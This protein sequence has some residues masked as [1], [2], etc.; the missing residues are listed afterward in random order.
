MTA[1]HRVDLSLVPLWEIAEELVHQARVVQSLELRQ[2]SELDRDARAAF[3]DVS[4]AVDD[5]MD[6]FDTA[7]EAAIEMVAVGEPVLPVLHDLASESW[8]RSL[9][10]RIGDLSAAA[11]RATAHYLDDPTRFFAAD[12]T[13]VDALVRAN[14]TYASQPDTAAAWRRT[15]TLRALPGS[16]RPDAPGPGGARPA[17]AENHDA[18]PPPRP[19]GPTTRPDDWPSDLSLP[20]PLPAVILSE[21]GGANVLHVGGPSGPS[22][23]P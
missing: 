16:P 17:P 11:G 10:A 12:A 8:L 21:D 18:E 23:H 9:P 7:R 22:L 14:A 20:A 4:A 1:E 13:F 6:A 15:H 2:D 5:V 19:I 3:A